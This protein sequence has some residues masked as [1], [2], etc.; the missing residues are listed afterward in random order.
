M[1]K[2][3][4]TV[5][6]NKEGKYFTLPSLPIV[7]LSVEPKVIK[8]YF[9]NKGLITSEDKGL[10]YLPVSGSQPSFSSKAK[11]SLVD[12][13]QNRLL[14]FCVDTQ[15]EEI[16][17]SYLDAEN[18][19]FTPTYSPF[20]TNSCLYNRLEEDLGLTLCT[21]KDEFVFED[22]KV[23]KVKMTFYI[24]EL[25][26]AIEDRLF[27]GILHF[28]SD[29]NGALFID[30][31][32]E[33]FN[34][35]KIANRLLICRVIDNNGVKY[36]PISQVYNTNGLNSGYKAIET[37]NGVVIKSVESDYTLRHSDLLIQTKP[38]SPEE[39][40]SNESNESN[41]VSSVTTL[42]K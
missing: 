24:N 19:Q 32:K 20:Y 41:K 29:A 8:D 10:S 34:A 28:K 38:Q 39:S 17:N 31:T 7:F 13:R 9:N 36:L 16:S 14:E 3:L 5:V 21:N 1:K 18:S 4:F 11:M 37:K 12:A 23:L 26:P 30:R 42:D 22:L 40:Q 25:S 27:E 2:N 15:I 35:I 6:K 33:N